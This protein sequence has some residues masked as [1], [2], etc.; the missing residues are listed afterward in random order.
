MKTLE[1]E[2][3]DDTMSAVEML[4]KSSNCSVEDLLVQILRE[5]A[6]PSQPVG[7]FRD[8]SELVDEILADIMHD[9]ETAH[10]RASG[11]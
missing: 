1:F 2:V 9:R 4:A 7:I 11:E 3:D 10:L 8:D 6:V 5:L